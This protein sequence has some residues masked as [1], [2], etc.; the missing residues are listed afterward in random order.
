MGNQGYG[1]FVLQMP[2]MI[3]NETE[4]IIF[5]GTQSSSILEACEGLR[6]RSSGK[7]RASDGRM[8]IDEGKGHEETDEGN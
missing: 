8:P 7:A 4:G 2:K 1:L 6:N 5:L 3:P